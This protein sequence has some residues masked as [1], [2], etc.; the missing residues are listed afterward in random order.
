MCGERL[1]GMFGKDARTDAELRRSPA[2]GDAAL[3]S[4]SELF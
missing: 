2:E 4:G 3:A 1:I